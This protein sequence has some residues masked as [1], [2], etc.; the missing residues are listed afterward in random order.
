MISLTAIL[1]FIS[2]VFFYLEIEIYFE[3]TNYNTKESFI[4]S[5][6]SKANQYLSK[7]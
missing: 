2:E 3:N 7:R 5:N 4:A 1:P 6:S